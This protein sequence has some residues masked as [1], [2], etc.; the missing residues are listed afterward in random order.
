MLILALESSAKP[1]SVA[2]FERNGSTD[3]LLGQEFQN[4]GY[5]H[6]RTLLAMAQTLL[7]NL[8]LK[9][10]DI[11]LIAV[12]NGPGSFT[13]VRIGVSAAKGLA[14]G[15]DVPICPVSTLEAMAYPTAQANAGAQTNAGT[16][17]CPVMDARREQVYNALFKWESGKLVRL[18]DDRAISIEELASDLEN[19]DIPFMPVGDG[20]DLVLSKLAERDILQ[21]EALQHNSLCPMPP[22]PDI[23][24][25]T[26]YGV[27][28]AALHVKQ[29]PASAA[30]PVYLRPSQ[31][32]RMRAELSSRWAGK[33]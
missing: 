20:T 25:Q 4:S 1:A 14:L 8:D 16:L 24:Y 22:T 27:A 19:L 5:S 12:A 33:D 32:E 2:V 13:G 31:A 23:K 10:T 7:Q 21:R 18:R 15:L 29:I 11:N 17:I 26:A 28:L 6:S 9:P 30:E 3:K